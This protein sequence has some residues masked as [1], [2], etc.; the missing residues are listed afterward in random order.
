[1]TP[2]SAR[3][4][5]GLFAV[6]Q[7]LV[8]LIVVT[9][10]LWWSSWTLF[11]ARRAV[12][13]DLFPYGKPGHL[14]AGLLAVVVMAG[15]VRG[16]LR[17]RRHRGDD[18]QF[19]RWLGR[20]DL[21]VF[22]SAAVLVALFWARVFINGWIP[23][24]V[25]LLLFFHPMA[26]LVCE[27]L[28]GGLLPLWN[29]WSNCGQPLLADPQAA[30]FYPLNLPVFLFGY[31][32]GFR[33]WL[34]IHMMTFFTFLYGWLRDRDLPP[35]SAAFGGFIGIFG[36]YTAW[37]AGY[38]SH[39]ASL[40]WM[41][42]LI[43]A[44]EKRAWIA[45]TVGASLQ[46]LAG[47]PQFH[48]M[49]LSVVAVG[50]VL[51]RERP[52]I[53]GK[54]LAAGIGG[55]GLV[56]FQS[57]PSWELIS[58]SVRAGALAY[59][60][61]VLYSL[62]PAEMAKFLFAPQWVSWS[63]RIAGDPH[64]MG[65]YI[66]LIPLVLGGIAVWRAKPDRILFPLV[67][68]GLGALLALGDHTPL[69]K[70][71]FH[72]VPGF[73]LFRF[74][75]QWMALALV[76]FVL[77]ASEGF[78]RLPARISWAALAVALADLFLFHQG[79]PYVY[80]EPAFLTYKNAATAALQGGAR[81]MESRATAVWSTK[82]IRRPE[83]MRVSPAGWVA[84]RDSLLMSQGVPFHIREAKSFG[85]H[86]PAA[87]ARWH[88]QA[89]GPIPDNALKQLGVRHILDIR[90]PSV[91][92]PG[93]FWR[94]AGE[95]WPRFRWP[96]GEPA[97]VELTHED[98][99]VLSLR[100]N[101][102]VDREKR[103]IVAEAYFPGWRA[104][105]DGRPRPLEPVEGIF[106]GVSVVPGD[107]RLLFRYDP[108]LFAAG[109][110]VSLLTGLFL[111]MPGAFRAPPAGRHPLWSGVLAI[112]GLGLLLKGGYDMAWGEPYA[113][114]FSSRPWEFVSAR[115]FLN[116]GAAEA[117]AGA[118]SLALAALS[119]RGSFQRGRKPATRA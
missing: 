38:A 53:Y 92:D 109:L 110:L 101:E 45:F 75:A 3:P 4:G 107:R 85:I 97:R 116:F 26:A 104:F 105:V 71:F 77:L 82:D 118:L 100:L 8:S 59:D 91:S 14:L 60:L 31:T 79:A 46:L 20:Q 93:F 36:A 54:L 39:L 43:H 99:H 56:A 62:S 1:M 65:F 78:Q 9:S 113:N 69:Y 24:N 11:A 44:A 19:G 30:V 111:W 114:L 102:G 21:I 6:S 80:T 66:G 40:V 117:F 84:L 52:L 28:Q 10:L 72:A 51:R 15:V 12:P 42:F 27:N 57:L 106:R 13:P 81:V 108:P 74:P 50:L 35:R 18:P 94:P 23:T 37:H 96:G 73:N 7:A 16:V 119:L 83:D 17:P 32:Q 5:P 88:Q 29:P 47:H 48:Y 89:H 2:V 67:L 41:P 22:T 95:P 64:I 76:G 58:R 98:A 63:P 49:S 25:L 61:A 115:R 33:L 34:F 55:L 68:I 86:T 112:L 87:V 90:D 70:V 103:L